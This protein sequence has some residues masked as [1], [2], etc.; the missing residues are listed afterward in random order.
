MT[1]RRENQVEPFHS[2]HHQKLKFARANE[3][4]GAEGFH[5]EINCPSSPPPPPHEGPG[6][7]IIF[8]I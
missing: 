2:H 3:D 4:V 5:K 7:G 6:L 8:I 1:N